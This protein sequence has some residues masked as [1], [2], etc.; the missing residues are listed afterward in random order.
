M[1]FEETVR[2]WSTACPSSTDDVMSFGGPFAAGGPRLRARV[3]A[4]VYSGFLSA[5]LI[6]RIQALLT[7][8]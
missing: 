5:D 2:L 1:I 3:S 4:R 7:A 6:N 8:F